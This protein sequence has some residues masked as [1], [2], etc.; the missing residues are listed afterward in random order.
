[1]LLLFCQ[2]LHN[3]KSGSGEGFQ[4]FIAVIVHVGLLVNPAEPEMI[5]DDEGV[6]PVVFGQV[7][8]GI[9]ELFDLLRIE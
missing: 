1:V 8:I 4:G 7:W 5:G 6:H 9:L 3:I 2:A